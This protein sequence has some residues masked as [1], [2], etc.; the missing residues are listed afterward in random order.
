M[1]LR[2]AR[3]NPREDNGTI[4]ASASDKPAPVEL[5]YAARGTSPQRRGARPVIRIVA[6][7]AAIAFA[8]FAVYAIIILRWPIQEFRAALTACVL[9][10]AFLACTAAGLIGKR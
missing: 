4:M 5:S 2:A 7:I 8:L 3:V 10:V 6:G 1:T 9:G